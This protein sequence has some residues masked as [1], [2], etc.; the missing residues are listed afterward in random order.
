MLRGLSSAR[1]ASSAREISAARRYS[2]NSSP[3]LG[4]AGASETTPP[5]HVSHAAVVLAATVTGND[6]RR[7]TVTRPEL[8]AFR[9]GGAIPR[10]AMLSVSRDDLTIPWL[11]ARWPSSGT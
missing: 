8:Y 3:K 5:C 6:V 11:P 7:S 10:V 2:V 9:A 4:L 1:R